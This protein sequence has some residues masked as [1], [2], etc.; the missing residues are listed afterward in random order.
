MIEESK[1]LLLFYASRYASRVSGMSKHNSPHKL[2]FSQKSGM[3]EGRRIERATET[4]L[5]LEVYSEGYKR[6]GRGGHRVDLDVNTKTKQ[7]KADSKMSS[8][9]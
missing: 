8:I 7:R 2:Y 9:L 1:R 5:L 3:S 6:D 4:S